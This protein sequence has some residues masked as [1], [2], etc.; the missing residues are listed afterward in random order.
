MTCS[1]LARPFASIFAQPDTYI[2]DVRHHS[3]AVSQIAINA[4][5]DICA[6]IEDVLRHLGQQAPLDTTST[7]VLL[8]RL[9]EWSSTLPPEIRLSTIGPSLHAAQHSQIVGSIHVACL[10]HFT[11][12][13]LTRPF[14]IQFLMSRLPKLSNCHG[15]TN[16]DSENSDTS[17]IARVSIDAAKYMAQTCHHA[18]SAGLI[19]DNMC[20][21]KY[22]HFLPRFNH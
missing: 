6:I 21:L 8:Q 4:N 17:K 13:L 22:E 2:R 14:L 16:M 10:Y 20:I 12:M 3:R 9:S 19:L 5:F 11:V 7:Q 15:G 18:L 1:I